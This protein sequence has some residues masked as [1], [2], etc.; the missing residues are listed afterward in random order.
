M[1]NM[2]IGTG[3]IGKSK[4]FRLQ[5]NL[6]TK[7]MSQKIN[8]PTIKTIQQPFLSKDTYKRVSDIF[9][10][11]LL[12]FYIAGSDAD[13]INA[14][15]DRLFYDNKS[16][17]EELSRTT[18][19]LNVRITGDGP[20][21]EPKTT[22]LHSDGELR[23]TFGSA[24]RYFA[25]PKRDYLIYKASGNL[26]Y[27]LDIVTGTKKTDVAIIVIDGPNGIGE[28]TKRHLLIASLLQI[29]N[30]IV[31]IDNIDLVGFSEE[32]YT[33]IKNELERIATLLELKKICFIPLSAKKGDNVVNASGNTP[34]YKGESLF[35]LLESIPV[36]N[37]DDHL[38]VRFPVQDVVIDKNDRGPFYKGFAGRVSGG[39]L[40]I[41]DIILALPSN[42][43]SS[44]KAI[45]E[46]PDEIIEASSSQS[47]ILRLD[48]N[49]DIN[50]GDLLFKLNQNYPK[51]SSIISI[52]VCWLNAKPLTL[53]GKYILHHTTD[54]TKGVITDIRYKVNVDN[55]QEIKDDK[56]VQINDIAHVTIKTLKP[57]KYDDYKENRVTG[58]LLLYDEHTLETVGTGM[59]VSDP[60]VFSYNI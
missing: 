3:G 19:E 36:Q 40:R 11:E 26:G 42:R 52:H 49:M 37:N 8:Q 35:Q 47:V 16:I 4:Y 58:S 57:L 60:E 53:G 1:Q 25:T 6:S 50:R 54:E 13:G 56:T 34:W 2:F 10:S 46:G 12:C 43:L 9:P 45:S 51:Y 23:T 17:P 32:I 39:V 29:P 48:G 31:A 21:L 24:N 44:I 14:F 20:N 7:D 33:T 55:F 18:K 30:V 5:L 59:I 28:Q 15:I 41:G 38:P 27:T 22:R